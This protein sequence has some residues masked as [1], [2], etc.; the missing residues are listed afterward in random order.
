M[1]PYLEVVCSSPAEI[2]DMTSGT[3]VQVMNST[4]DYQ[5][6]VNVIPSSGP[7]VSHSSVFFILLPL[8]KYVF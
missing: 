4:F 1:P 5:N 7:C 8:I 6:I 3:P 2:S